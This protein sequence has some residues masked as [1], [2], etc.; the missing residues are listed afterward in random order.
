MLLKALCNPPVGWWRRHA[1]T[2]LI[3]KFTVIFLFIACMQVSATGHSQKVTIYQT[4]VSLKK[5][6]KEIENQSGYHFFYKDKLLRQAVNVSLN[7]NNASVEEALDQCFLDQPL[8]Y[9]IVDKIVV[10]KERKLATKPE[11]PALSQPPLPVPVKGLVKDEK[12]DPIPGVSVVVTGTERG[13]STNADGKFSIDANAGEVLEFS[14]VGYKKTRITVGSNTDLTIQLALE[15][16][17]NDEVVIVGYG[18]KKKVNLT[19]A[20]SVVKGSDL[21]N[22]PVL[23]ATQSLQGMIPGLNVTVGTSTKPGQ[24]FNLNI[25]G[26]GN[27]A[28][29][30]GPFVLVDGMPMDLS[31][32]NPN[33]IE[34]ISVLKDAAA[35]AVYGARA[36]FGVILVTTKKGKVDRTTVS[37]SNNFGLTRPVNLPDMV[38]S[39]DFALYFN[40]AT[41]NAQGS[42]QYSDAKLELLKKYIND[43]T[44]IN[45]FP[46]AT[47]NYLSNWENTANGVANTDWF[48]F[49]YKPRAGRQ[50]HNLSVSGGNKTTQYFVSGGY[51]SEGG[52]LRYADINYNRLNF[53]LTLTSQVTNW[54]KLKFNSKITQGK[55]EAPFSS[56]GTFESLFFHN[57]ARMRPNISPYDLNGNFNEISSVPY[58]Q[59]GSQAI[60]K[61]F[62][63]ALLPG[64]ELEPVKNWKIITDF[65]IRRDDGQ[66]STLLLPGLI[67]GIDGTPKYVNRSEFGIPLL[68]SYSRNE[69]SNVYISPNIYTSYRYLLKEDHE[70]NL[71]VGFQQEASEFRSLTSSAQDLISPNRPGILLTTGTP[72]TTES[73][74]HWATRGYF[75]RLSYNYK[76]KYLLE[77]DGRYDGSSR[78]SPDSRWGFFPSVS[79]GYNIAKEG[80]MKNLNHIINNLKIR[81]SYG[82]LGNQSGAGLY[83]YIQSMGISV[84]GINGA[85]PGWF[86]QNGREANIFAPAPFNQGTTWEK[87]YTKNIGLDFDLF[88][89]RLSGSADVYQRETKDMLGPTFDIADLFGGSVPASNNANLRTR[90]W[91]LSLNYRGRI[92]KDI[93]FSLGG[94][95]SNSVTEV[96]KYQNPTFTDPAGSWYVG[97]K[98]GEIWGYRADGLVQNADQAT[99]FNT[100]DHSF[101]SPVAWKPGDVNYLDLN[102]D[103]KINRGN[104]RLGDM[105]DLGIIGNSSPRYAYSFTGSVQWR[106]LAVSLMVQGIG[107]RDFAPGVGDVYF[108]GSGSLAQVT[109]FPQHMDYWTP[110]NPNAYYPNPYA[111]PAGSIGSFVNKTQQVADR[112]LQNAAYLRL[113]NATISYSLPAGL[114]RRAKLNKVSLFVSGENLFTI[115]K[116]SKM[117]DPETLIGVGGT[118]TGK[119]YPL[120]QAYSFGVNISL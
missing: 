92:G 48:D 14:F 100:L 118:T 101:L 54:A 120:S 23:N 83:S 67:Y 19:G 20:V 78:F 49:Q 6:F 41:F 91:E 38:N 50:M 89:N 40:A 3:M 21:E 39:Y 108:W 55:Y 46:E 76:E 80:F 18:T 43:P 104:N 57:L 74:N 29:G 98:A 66:S 95:L 37:Y 35:S 119:I 15:I 115:T 27:L 103:K 85:G 106:G 61:G 68:G 97:K 5:V 111:A 84:P 105:G 8:T 69:N 44:G 13:T 53:N 12:G 75:G 93:S 59:S 28:G 86:F 10:I 60:N 64:L 42:K 109:V 9:T 22:R 87:V 52:V 17:A 114:I 73:R 7:V 90:G 107:K 96:T 82:L 30:D 63:L 2:L 112:Y 113:K 16:T 65:N 70:F 4:N 88:Q 99:Q 58:F 110:D 56:G 62:T 102:G 72:T 116:L 31:D 26:A 47:D 45:I 33:D 81:G 36:P 71:M 25:R 79:A 11:L 117:F 1:K 32:I 94:V 77:L 24:S 51:Y 34:S